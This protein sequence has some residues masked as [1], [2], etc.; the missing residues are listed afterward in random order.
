MKKILIIFLFSPIYIMSQ[1]PKEFVYL[2]EA[3]PSLSIEIR[4]ATSNNFMGTPIKGYKSTDKAVGTIELANALKKAEKVFNSYG[5]GI[6]IYDSYRPQRA[7]DDF[8][9]WSKVR[10]DTINKESYYPNLNKNI[11]F[12]LGFIAKKSGH[13]RGST[14][15]LTLIYIDGENKG[16]EIDMG[17]NWDY[18]GDL[19]YYSY[20]Q[21]TEKQKQNRKLLRETLI[22]CGFIP[23]DKEWWHFTLKK[24]PFPNTYFDFIIN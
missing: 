4:Y 3:I 22:N 13:S 15:D 9:R 5:L 20:S 19:S 10:W 12:D 14:I 16:M 2:N 6:K 24:E 8:I 1:L 7:V 18:F 23:Y 17:G 11:L 21:I